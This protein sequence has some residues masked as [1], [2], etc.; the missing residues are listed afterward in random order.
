MRRLI[1]VLVSAAAALTLVT[2]GT[3]GAANAKPKGPCCGDTLLINRYPGTQ[4]NP[5][6]TKVP[7]AINVVSGGLANARGV[8]FGSYSSVH[9]ILSVAAD[10]TYEIMN[11]TVYKLPKGTITTG[12]P[13]TFQPGNTLVNTS[14]QTV[15]ITGGT[16]LYA[17]VAGTAT[18]APNPQ[19]TEITF[20][21]TNK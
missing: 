14:K 10:G 19:S 13:E 20:T 5:S 17:G 1:A 11:S 6:T 16:G 8:V 2:A 3:A 7:G 15:V 21:F 12:G 4:S 9:T 18:S